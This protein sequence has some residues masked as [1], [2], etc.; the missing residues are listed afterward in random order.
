M[1]KPAPK[2]MTVRVTV[3]INDKEYGAE[4]HYQSTRYTIDKEH[5]LIPASDAEQD[6]RRMLRAAFSL[7]AVERAYAA[8]IGDAPEVDPPAVTGETI[9]ELK[10][11]AS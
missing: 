10:S 1:P 2:P 11:D 5:P 9:Q 8:A 6:V 7:V 4:L 3:G